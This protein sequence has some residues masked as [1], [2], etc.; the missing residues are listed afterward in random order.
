MKPCFIMGNNSRLQVLLEA[1][2]SGINIAV[3]FSSAKLM[4]LS[5]DA[6]II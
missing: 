1:K 5:V 4:M 2:Y 3:V 6:L